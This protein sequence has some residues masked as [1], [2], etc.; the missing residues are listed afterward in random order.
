L[1]RKIKYLFS[2][3]FLFV[4]SSCVT[5]KQKGD[6]SAL[7][8]FYHNTTSHYNG[9]FNANELVKESVFLLESKHQ[10][11]Y[12]KILPVYPYL[13]SENP[14]SVAENLDNAIK[15]VSIVG[16]VHEESEWLDDCYILIGKSQFIKQD[17]ESAE[18]TLEFF[19]DEFNPLKP[20]KRV[21]KKKVSTKKKKGPQK[22]K[23]TSFQKK[24]DVKDKKEVKK[25]STKKK[26]KRRK[27]PSK[28]KR[29]RMAKKK[30]AASA[31]EA[32][33]AKE[34]AST[35]MQ[36]SPRVSKRSPSLPGRSL[37]LAYPLGS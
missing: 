25:K 30:K 10:D 7:G 12:N 13:A 31:K 6:T 33:K 35:Y 37:I 20:R 14:E 36:V 17:F 15:K 34:D 1:N 26:K 2:F 3:F 24:Q 32:K 29:A 22:P 28:K 19:Q 16:R 23:K 21:S 5:Q 27:P 8:K 18:E 9:Y 11:N 4:L